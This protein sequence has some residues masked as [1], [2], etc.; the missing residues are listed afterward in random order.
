MTIRIPGHSTLSGRPETILRAMADARYF[1]HPEGEAYI[2]AVVAD[3]RKLEIDL[4]VTGDTYEERAA[5]LLR[6]MA[7]HHMIILEEEDR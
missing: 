2:E 6:E 7:K 3:A 4:H 1:D 5:S